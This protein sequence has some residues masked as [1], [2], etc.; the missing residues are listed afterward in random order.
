LHLNRSDFTLNFTAIVL[1]EGEN[2]PA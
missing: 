1:I 2:D